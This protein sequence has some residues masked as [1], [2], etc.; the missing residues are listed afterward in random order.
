MD[1]VVG[2]DWWVP[3]LDPAGGVHLVD[4]LFG[5]LIDS[6]GGSQW[7][8]PSINPVEGSCCRIPLVDQVDGSLHCI[9]VVH[10]FVGILVDH[11]DV[12]PLI[13]PYGISRCSIPL[14]CGSR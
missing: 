1:L 9:P 2:S 6:C 7:W 3:L 14:A 4:H 13:D 5:P 11:A 10:P 12:G 8:I